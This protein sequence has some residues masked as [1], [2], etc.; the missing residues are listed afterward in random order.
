MGSYP[1]S[2]W[3]E[4]TIIFIFA[5]SGG[6]DWFMDIVQPFSWAILGWIGSGVAKAGTALGC[7]ALMCGLCLVLFNNKIFLKI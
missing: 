1:G 6:A 3:H 7:L 4:P 5:R 2:Y